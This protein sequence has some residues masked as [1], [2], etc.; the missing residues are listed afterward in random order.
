MSMHSEDTR[1]GR[2]SGFD[3][4][5]A[6]A[7][8]LIDYGTLDV[9]TRF[10]WTTRGMGLQ[11]LGLGVLAFVGRGQL[12]ILYADRVLPALGVG[13]GIFLL[14]LSLVRAA[15]PALRINGD[16]VTFGRQPTIAWG[17]VT[18]AWLE[19]TYSKSGEHHTLV[20][21]HRTIDRKAQGTRRLQKSQLF[22]KWL[23]TPYDLMLRALEAGYLRAHGKPI[24]V[25]RFHRMWQR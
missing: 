20:I 21:E 12:G 4:G 17:D 22:S 23:D 1:D 18:G 7:P 16:G 3:A 5:D 15:P 13:S 25:R 6:A 2:A 10:W 11:L 19:R 8:D 14:L 24:P 9:N